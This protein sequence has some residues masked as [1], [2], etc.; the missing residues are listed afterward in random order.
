MPRPAFLLRSSLVALTA[1]ALAL[2]ARVAQGDEQPSWTFGKRTTSSLE[3]E[4]APRD[5]G[6]EHDGV[7]GRL[8]GDLFLSLGAGA[9]LGDGVRAGAL[10]RALWF[11]TAGVTLGYA[12]SPTD[13]AELERVLLVGAELRPLF[14]PRF[15]L[16]L[17]GAS[18]LLDLTLDSLSLGAG[19]CFASIDSEPATAFELSLGLGVPLLARARGP[20][21]EARAALRPALATDSGQLFV[22]VSWYE[23]VETTLVR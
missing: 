5:D 9:E 22:L 17:E 15:A 16:N 10:A 4:A 1:A 8:D 20:W 12:R 21:L 7:Y 23:A 13:G 3:G 2:S 19:A 11:Q 6:L 14:L 18:S